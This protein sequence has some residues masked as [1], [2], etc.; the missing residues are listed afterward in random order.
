MNGLIVLGFQSP[1]KISTK[2]KFSILKL[3]KV[4][5]PKLMRFWT[6]PKDT[7]SGIPKDNKMKD[8]IQK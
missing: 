1:R 7:T 3:D 2:S 5:K 6:N 8:S 4:R